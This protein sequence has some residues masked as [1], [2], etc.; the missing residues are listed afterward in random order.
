MLWQLFDRYPAMFF[1]TI[2]VPLVGGLGTG[3]IA[4][5]VGYESLKRQFSS[6][7]QSQ[8]IEEDLRDLRSNNSAL[9]TT[10]D[11][12]R[13]YNDK[14]IAA[15]SRDAVLT[16]LI[17]QYQQLS[18]ATALFGQMGRSGA[19]GDQG[20]VAAEILKI[21]NEDVVHA[22]VR[23]DLPGKPLVIELAPNSFRVI[24]PVPM[25][26]PPNLTFTGLPVGVSAVV[27]D[28]SEI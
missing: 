21:L 13:S 17:N 15:G 16:A 18:R 28:K 23:E 6:S 8:R 7:E 14:I 9:A 5:W 27:S 12:L 11:L 3:I 24:N 26:V 1:L 25:R 4:S 20:R 19:T 2:V 10:I 22:S